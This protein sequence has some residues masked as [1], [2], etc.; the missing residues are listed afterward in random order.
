VRPGDASRTAR[1]AAF[2]RAAHQ[3]IEGGRIFSD[4][5]AISVLGEDAETVRREAW[6]RPS[7]HFMRIFIASRTRFAEDALS[8]AIDRG[9]RQ[10]VVLGAGLDTYAYRGARREV[11]R[12]FEADHPATQA[13]KRERLAAA[14]IPIPGSLAF[15][16]VD[17]ER[18]TLPDAL[19]RAGFDREQHAFFMWL[20]CVPYLTEDAIWTTLGFIASLRA[21]ADVVFD[22]ADPP[23]TLA[24]E[25]RERH[26]RRAAR[27]AELGEAWLTY[28]DPPELHAGLK[29]LGFNEIEDLGP[30]Q[31][32]ACYSS[33]GAEAAPERGDHVLRASR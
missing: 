20:G 28:F 31:I 19:E 13:W 22:Y 10:L 27:V 6:A 21:A 30:P 18:Q 16:P 15:A 5:L 8:A 17:F 32:A 25:M 12:I 7:S 11:L 26:A 9:A 3:V 23:E 33:Q 2:H 1:A 14:G 4:P 24:P 29:K